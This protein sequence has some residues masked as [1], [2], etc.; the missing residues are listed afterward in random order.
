LRFGLGRWLRGCERAQTKTAAF[1]SITFVAAAFV[2][3]LKNA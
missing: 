1:H 2:K 3:N